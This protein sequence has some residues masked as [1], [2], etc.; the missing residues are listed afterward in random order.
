MAKKAVTQKQKSSTSFPYE[1][2]ENYTNMSEEELIG[3]IKEN[4]LK[5][6]VADQTTLDYASYRKAADLISRARRVFIAGFRS[7]AGFASSLSIMLSYVRPSVY[8]VSTAHP[9]VDFLVDIN[10]DDVLIAL[11]YERYSSDT[12]FAF[13]MAKKSGSHIITFT[14]KYTS[15]ICDGAEVIILNAT[16]NLAFYNSYVS[17]TMS[18]EVLVG[19]VSR[20][21]MEQ[22]K[23]RLMMMEEYLRETGQY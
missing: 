7:C 6:I 2:I 14:D 15:P 10:T 19:L 1:K 9:L 22:N 23:E 5:N 17:L 13:N 3:C 20:K 12:I 8:L 18:I 21:N 16:E 4:A 11:S